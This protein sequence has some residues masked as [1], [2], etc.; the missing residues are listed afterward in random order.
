MPIGPL[1]PGTPTTV[2]PDASPPPYTSTQGPA[3]DG[4]VV[5]DDV[6]AAHLIALNIQ[7]NLTARLATAENSI[8]G[9][10]TL[11]SARI[12]PAISSGF[13]GATDWANGGDSGTGSRHWTQTAN[14]TLPVL[15]ELSPYLPLS[16][17]LLSIGMRI[18]P[19][20]GHA[21]LPSVLPTA[22][23]YL[24]SRA[25]FATSVDILTATH[26]ATT[27]AQYEN[28]VF[29]E[30]S[31][32]TSHLINHEYYM[33]YVRFTGESGTNYIG[34]LRVYGIELRVTP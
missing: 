32:G 27:V 21:G 7:Q 5:A 19:A 1:V 12:F 10:S 17:R 11:T 33:Y 22:T 9:I 4:P 3:P 23:L 18:Q 25:N 15:C 14:S 31:L 29:F 28:Y 2:T 34:G 26:S 20:S 8:P 30:A 24:V 16:G 13:G 6:L